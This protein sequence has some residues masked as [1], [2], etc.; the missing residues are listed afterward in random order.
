MIGTVLSG[1][2]EE[3]IIHREEIILMSKVGQIQNGD[4]LKQYKDVNEID[5][6]HASCISPDFISDQLQESLDRLQMRA[7]DVYFLENPEKCRTE[8]DTDESFYEKIR[9]AFVH[10]EHLVSQKKIQRY[11]IASDALPFDPQQISLEKCLQIAKQINS[12]HHFQFIQFPFNIQESDAF[13]K[14]IYDNK[15][16]I[17]FANENKLTIISNRSF[18]AN[19]NGKIYR[20]V[21]TIVENDT[22]TFDPTKQ[23]DEHTALNKFLK[24]LNDTAKLELSFPLIQELKDKPTAQLPP[25]T[26]LSW[27]QILSA[28]MG[29]LDSLHVWENVLEN[30]IKPE[31][32]WATEK[33]RRHSESSKFTDWIMQYNFVSMVKFAF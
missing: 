16:L 26:S 20:Y 27:A 8:S 11:G 6:F 10:L 31:M 9:N 18:N 5:R 24:T 15:S 13:T 2:M 32:R 30:R 19:M 23:V 14:K 25:Q 22:F 28:K 29:D 21:D 4:H 3:K 1:M 12:N 17:Q 33:L 7:L